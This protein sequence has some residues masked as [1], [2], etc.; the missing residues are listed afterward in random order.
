[1]VWGPGQTEPSENDV[2]TA[3]HGISKPFDCLAQLRHRFG[4]GTG[5]RETGASLYADG[6]TNQ[7]RKSH[8]NRKILAANE[9]LCL[10]IQ[11]GS[12]PTKPLPRPHLLALPQC[13]RG[14]WQSASAPKRQNASRAPLVCS[15]ILILSA[16]LHLTV[17]EKTFA[18]PWLAF[19]WSLQ[20][21][22]SL[23]AANNEQRVMESKAEKHKALNR[24]S[25]YASFA[26]D[27]NLYNEYFQ[28]K[29]TRT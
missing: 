4:A 15:K 10:C 13:R 7:R 11:S 22:L 19:S 27:I 14:E 28:C 26:A 21:L 3:R 9:S 18:F 2:S 17:G 20:L 8:L 24:I 12:K 5:G 16:K 25:I 23:F 29:Y 1:M 6:T